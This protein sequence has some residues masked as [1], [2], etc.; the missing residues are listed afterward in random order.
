MRWLRKA[1]CLLL[2][3]LLPA[4]AF[5]PVVLDRSRSTHVS[6]S[7]SSSSNDDGVE[8]ALDFD[9]QSRINVALRAV[10]QLQGT[11]YGGEKKGDLASLEALP[12]ALL[13]FTP[14]NLDRLVLGS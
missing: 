1:S 10:D 11:S 6:S 3:L 8:D 14:P 12:S 2:L 7:S 13:A 9:I 4:T 5:R